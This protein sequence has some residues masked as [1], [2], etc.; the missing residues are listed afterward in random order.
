MIAQHSLLQLLLTEPLNYV[1]DDLIVSV[2]AVAAQNTEQLFNR[3]CCQ[4]FFLV[5]GKEMNMDLFFGDRQIQE[6]F[7]EPVSSS[8]VSLSESDTFASN[9]MSE[10]SFSRCSMLALATSTLCLKEAVITE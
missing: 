4:N 1:E 2:V 3:V 10:N 6:M 7:S 5:F 9:L 8:L